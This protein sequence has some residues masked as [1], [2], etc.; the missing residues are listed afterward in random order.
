MSN[1]VQLRKKILVL[2]RWNAGPSQ[3]YPSGITFVGSYL[4]TW[5]ERGTESCVFRKTYDKFRWLGPEPGPL[6]VELSALTMSHCTSE[7]RTQS[8]LRK[9]GSIGQSE[10]SPS[11]AS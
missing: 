9:G 5:A 3:G 1:Y 8:Y 11:L 10:T 4:Y 2:H 6:D 7:A